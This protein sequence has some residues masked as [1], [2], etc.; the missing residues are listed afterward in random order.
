VRAPAVGGWG[1]AAT[2]GFIVGGTLA[3]DA[4]GFVLG[5]WFLVLLGALVPYLVF[6]PRVRQGRFAGAWGWTLAWAFLQSVVMVTAVLLF[7]ER[8]SEAVMRGPAYAREMLAWVRTGVGPEGSPRLFLP[9]HIRHYLGFCVLSVITVGY[10]GLALGTWLLDYM[11]YYVAEL[12]RASAQ[13][14]GA[15]VFGWPVWAVLRVA[16]FTATGTAMAALG[17]SWLRRTRGRGRRDA[18]LFPRALL[19][20]GFGLV[21]A[22]A[23]IKAFLAAAWHRMLLGFLTGGS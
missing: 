20:A 1:T 2:A 19:A 7:P 14:W 11:N 8:A 23:V 13:P 12:I 4:L 6:L 5:R 16:G 21:V 22:D 15:A 10:A 17:L 3:A 9:I 18:P